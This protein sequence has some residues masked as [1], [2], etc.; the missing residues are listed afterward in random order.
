MNKLVALAFIFAL[1]GSA[2]QAMPL[3]PGQATANMIIKVEGGCG[4]GFHRGSMG[5]CRPNR[6]EAV[7]VVPGAVIVAPGAGPCGGRG[8]HRACF[9]D[10]HC[11]MICN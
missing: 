3:A 1:S 10:G 5:G 7:V 6:G 9:P 4:P 8:R 2:A 11:E